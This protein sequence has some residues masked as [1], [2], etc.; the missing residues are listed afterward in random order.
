MNH[1]QVLGVTSQ[2]DES[3]IKRAYAVLIK[4]YRPDTHPD[5]FARIRSA[6]E[7]AMSWA[8]SRQELGGTEASDV[9]EQHQV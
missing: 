6:Y 5:E 8:R 1:F 3:I 4:Q 2:A 9:E 7:G